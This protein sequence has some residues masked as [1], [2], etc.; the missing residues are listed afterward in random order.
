MRILQ[1]MAGGE[2]GGAETAFVDMCIALHEAGETI[3]VVTRPNDIRVPRL[4][5][6]GI[7]VH[8]LAFGGK[9]DVFT[10]WKMRRIIRAFRPDIVQSWMSR[11][12]SKVPGWKKSMGI[13]RYY[14]VARLGNY[15][16]MKYFKSADGFVG[17][18]PE[19]CTYIVKHTGRAERVRHINNFA[20][21]ETVEQAAERGAYG[22]PEGA[23]LLLGLGRLHDDKAFDTL[24]Q[25]VA[26]MP[27]V[28]AWIA[29]EGPDRGKLEALIEELG[30]G[31]RVTLLGWR[32]DRAALLQACDICTFISRDEPFGT[33]F[34]QAWAQGT[35]VVVCDSDGPR[36]FVRHEED[37]MMAPIDDIAAIKDCIQCLIDDADLAEK[38]VC[39]GRR[40]YEAEFTKET[41]L[42]GYLQFYHDIQSSSFV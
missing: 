18:T 26:Q 37:G 25:V 23:P 1:V 38:L 40:R 29:G 6:A 11:A 30:V 28:Y 13:A 4:R 36:Q 34:V 39:N 35:P 17:I 32:T 21:V 24:I 12:P 20:E 41:C 42:Q 14:H 31:E 7:K 9:V 15:Y 19:V 16:K 8:T 33:V 22:V 27:G 10:P 2:H 5:A 3:E